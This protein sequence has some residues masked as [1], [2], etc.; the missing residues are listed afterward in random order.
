MLRVVMYSYFAP[1]V[2]T[3]P[4]GAQ[5]ALHGLLR[6]LVERD[7]LITFLCPPAPDGQ[8]LVDLGPRLRIV[9]RLRAV[10]SS[11]RGQ[12][13]PDD[14]FHDHLLLGRECR[15]A[16]VVVSFDRPFPVAVACPVVLAVNSFAY[17]HETEAVL[18]G[19]WDAIVVPSGYLA[20]CISWYLEDGWQGG[21][22][23]PVVVIPHGIDLPAPDPVRQR[24]L[25]TE[26]SIS[27]GEGPY[28][29]F[30]HRLDPDKGFD[31]AVRTVAGLRRRG[32]RATLLVPTPADSEIWAHQRSHLAARHDMVAALG[33]RDAVRFHR[34]IARAEL[35]AYLR[36]C[37][38]TLNLSVLPE[39]FGLTVHE[40]IAAGVGVVS[41]PAGALA[42]LIPPGHGVRF[43]DF[44]DHRMAM[45]VI[46][47]RPPSAT[48]IANGRRFLAEERSW[49]AAADQWLTLLR[50]TRVCRTPFRATAPSRP[51]PWLRT[52]PS[53][54]VWDDYRRA[55]LPAAAQPEPI[56]AL[57]ARR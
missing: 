24:A 56:P 8:P 16:D 6:A 20:R 36:C 29:S 17:A 22:A 43:V 32:V 10:A 3:S 7:M 46:L 19:N 25:S 5:Q 11:N 37:Q 27:D 54:R 23:R 41:T 44:A 9:D 53:G 35:P 38:W 33:V 51:S 1:L 45:S 47:G 42:E 26:L 14:L 18:A 21:P 57:P 49:A 40:S 31:T 2:S 30:P 52:L 55:Y 15:A 34:W 28:L 50:K 48:E 13:G 12:Y 39:A 4:G